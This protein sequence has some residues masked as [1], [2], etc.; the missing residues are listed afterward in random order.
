MRITES[1]LRRIIRQ[2]VR[3]L[4]ESKN[5]MQIIMD[6]LRAAG[7]DTDDADLYELSSDGTRIH[8]PHGS[9]DVEDSEYLPPPPV[10]YDAELAKED[11]PYAGRFKYDPYD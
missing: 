3:A 11:K 1:Q 5:E 7:Y 8:G 2:E 10:K 9:F 6:T 4:R